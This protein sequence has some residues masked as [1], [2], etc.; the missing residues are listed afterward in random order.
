MTGELKPSTVEANYNVLRM[1][2]R[3]AVLD[4]LLAVNPTDGVRLPRK[5]KRVIVPMDAAEVQALADAIR[6]DLAAAVLLAASCG[7]RQGELLGLTSDRVRWLRREV[8]I[9]RQLITPPRGVPA[10]SP[11]KTVA[12]NRIVPAPDGVLHVLGQHI[13]AFGPGPDGLLFHD[14]G[15]PWRRSRVGDAWRV[16]RKVSGVEAR[17]HDLRHFCASTLI[18]A[19]VSV[20][21]VQAVLGHATAVETLEVYAHLWPADHDRTRDA[22]SSALGAFADS[23][24]T[25]GTA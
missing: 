2:L 14:A 25:A 7:V 10:L 15:R 6:P 4:R 21:G 22:M 5:D 18:D 13:E 8:V 23:T 1:M 16:A 17:F 9:D 24:R 12:S 11:V 3:A 20:K 19:G